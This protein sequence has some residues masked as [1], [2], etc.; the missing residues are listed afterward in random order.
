MR[1]PV[2][3][4][5]DSY[6]RAAETIVAL[7]AVGVPL[8]DISLIS[9]TDAEDERAGNKDAIAANWGSENRTFEAAGI[10][11]AIGATA[12]TAAGLLTLFAIPGI[13][14]VVGLG[15]LLPLLGG[16]AI[17]GVTGGIVGA[18]TNAG[19]SED[20]AHVYAEGIRR[21]GAVVTARVPAKDERQVG[22]VMDRSAVD[23]RDR[24]EEYRASG[25]LAFDPD[26]A[27]YQDDQLS[28]QRSA[29]R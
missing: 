11:A 5:Y 26:A 21:G 14:P 15:W 6:V 20:D 8:S 9:N 24:R 7:E 25:W 4:L 19:M 29:V 28:N 17:G 22:D 18:L 16:A 2:Y 3:R 13:G 23:V 12:G 27:P 10:G 1:V